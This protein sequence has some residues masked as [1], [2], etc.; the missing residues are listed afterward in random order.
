MTAK[1][2][3]LYAITPPTLSSA[4]LFEAVL[5]A[6]LGGANWVQY[7]RKNHSFEEQHQEAEVLCSLC[8][9]HGALFLVNDDPMLAKEVK[10]DGVHLGQH[11][12]TV[13]AAR[14]ILGKNALIGVSCHNSLLLAQQSERAGADYVSFGSF[15]HSN[16]KSEAPLARLS[17]LKEAKASLS[18][19]VVAIGGITS[20]NVREVLDAGADRVAVCEGLFPLLHKFW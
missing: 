10:A 5:E 1:L 19:P 15:F 20:D 13:Q 9:K 11:D 3:G 14:N 4:Q 8:R 7:R 12:G 2:Y 17:I 18:I 16:T 6:I